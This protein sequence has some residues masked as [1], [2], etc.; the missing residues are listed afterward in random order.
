MASRSEGLEEKTRHKEIMRG[1]SRVRNRR[2]GRWVVL[3]LVLLGVY[4][5]AML[6]RVLTVPRPPLHEVQAIYVF[7]GGIPRRAECAARLYRE[8]IAPTVV[9]SGGQVS[10]KVAALGSPLTDA[11]LNAKVAQRH[12]VP[13]NAEVVLETATSTWQDA[14]ALGQWMR[15]T[16]V[17]KVLAIT[18]ATHARRAWY[19]LRLALGDEATELRLYPCDEPYDALWWTEEASLTRVTEETL[20]LGL[21]S[22]RYFLPAALGFAPAASPSGP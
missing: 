16:Q 9:F 5:F 15:S 21:Y 8:K 7:P 18:S 13:A 17:S 11:R 2:G 4:L 22:V 3:A 14:L 19:S 20:K 1:A 12:G 10:P 6:P